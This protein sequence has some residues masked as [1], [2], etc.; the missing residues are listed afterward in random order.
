MFIKTWIVLKISDFICSYR[1][2]NNGFLKIV[3]NL[4]GTDVFLDDCNSQL[5][6]CGEM[7]IP[8][9]KA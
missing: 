4:A 6:S 5:L 2:C 3:P 8:E 7:N 9:K 1:R